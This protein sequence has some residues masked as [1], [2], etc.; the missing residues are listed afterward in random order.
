[1][2]LL[3]NQREN[4]ADEGGAAQDLPGEAQSEST[5]GNSSKI[6][7]HCAI[8]FSTRMESPGRFIT[9]NQFLKLPLGG[10]ALL[11][12]FHLAQEFRGRAARVGHV[13]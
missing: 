4:S 11:L 9:A 3:V 12:E 5:T 1:M 2:S 7:G 8:W 6:R 13:N 10:Q